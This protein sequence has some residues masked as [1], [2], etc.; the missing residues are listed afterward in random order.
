MAKKNKKADVP[1]RI[2]KM[3]SDLSTR[4]LKGKA[5]VGKTAP[6]GMNKSML[7]GSGSM[8]GPKHVGKSK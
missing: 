4:S 6:A 7:S 8:R 5:K 2:A 1:P 3:D